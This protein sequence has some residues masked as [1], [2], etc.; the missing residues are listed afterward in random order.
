MQERH[1]HDPA[2]GSEG[3]LPADRGTI[4]LAGV[5]AAR[6]ELCR[7]GGLLRR[8]I[9]LA[10]AQDVPAEQLARAA[11]TSVEQVRRVA[12]ELDD[13]AGRNAGT[14]ADERGAAC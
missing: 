12:T 8:A 13:V 1:T 14:R 7:A 11:G 9:A 3:V 5:R 6:H 2:A 4:A 10:A